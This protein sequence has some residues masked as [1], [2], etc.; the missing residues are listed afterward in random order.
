[1][2]TRHRTSSTRSF[3]SSKAYDRAMRWAPVL[4][5]LGACSVPEGLELDVV[6]SDPIA[7]VELIP[8]TT[9]ETCP[10]RLAAP[11]TDLHPET[12]LT[13]TQPTRWTDDVV[14]GHAQFRLVSDNGNESFN[15][16]VI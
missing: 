1:M 9:C 8:A 14:N 11:G 16:L 6:T 4:V 3:R 7:R 5:A 13:S 12:A 10:D 15:G 2:S